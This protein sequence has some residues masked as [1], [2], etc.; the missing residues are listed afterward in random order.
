MN[1]T[2]TITIT[3]NLAYAGA[4]PIQLY[5]RF[6]N[7]STPTP[8]DLSNPLTSAW[9]NGNS[10]SGIQTGSGNYFTPSDYTQPQTAGLIASATTSGEF[11]VY[12]PVLIIPSDTTEYLY[13]RIGLP[14]S[15]QFSFSY[16]TAKMT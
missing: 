12:I 8:T 15:S 10:Q 1:T 2:A 13:C 5:Y 14:M 11:S 7:Q 6:E 3:N 9:I 16:I 4:N